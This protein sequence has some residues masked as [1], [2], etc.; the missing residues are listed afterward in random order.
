MASVKSSGSLW[1]ATSR[2]GAIVSTSKNDAVNVYSTAGHYALVHRLYSQFGDAKWLSLLNPLA[3]E[4]SD[5]H[6]SH[7][8]SECVGESVIE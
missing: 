8:M 1:I 5:T 2:C 6:T 7:T 4:H 3:L